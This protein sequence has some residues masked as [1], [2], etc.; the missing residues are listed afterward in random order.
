MEKLISL[1]Q[2]FLMKAIVMTEN[3][4]NLEIKPETEFESFTANRE[5]L[6]QVIEQ[7]SAEID[8]DQVSAETRAEFSK[9]IDYIKKLDEK[10]LTKLQEYKVELKQDIEK[11]VRQKESVKGY[12]LSDVK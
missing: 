4:I 5:R 9:Q 6:F 3:M 2:E 1:F 10:L 7:I 12:N 8:W 11:T